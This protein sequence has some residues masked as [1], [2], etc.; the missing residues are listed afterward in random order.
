[1]EC[2]LPPFSP[3][4]HSLLPSLSVPAHPVEEAHQGVVKNHCASLMEF[5][6]KMS[7]ACKKFESL[8][9]EHVAQ[10]VTF[11]IKIARV[12]PSVSLGSGT[13]GEGKEDRTCLQKGG[14]QDVP[15]L[16]GMTLFGM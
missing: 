4:L 8:E 2:L 7:E 11:M 10:M 1:M 5:Q 14:F 12:S 13:R 6:G 3:S 9:E 15:P 16:G